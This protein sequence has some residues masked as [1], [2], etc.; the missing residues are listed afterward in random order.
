MVLVDTSVWIDHFYKRNEHLVTLLNSGKVYTHE[1]VI[2]E[3]AC[4]NIANR[5]EILNLL[6]ALSFT[7]SVTH[8]E[9][10]DFISIRHLFGR[11]L[12]YIDI[13][14]LASSLISDV[15]LWTKNKKLN[16]VANELGVAYTFYHHMKQTRL[17]RA[18]YVHR[19][20]GRF[21]PE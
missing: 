14:I 1:Y 3:I 11:G 2:G 10:L 20:S 6:K 12:G 7:S 9:I 21:A 5:D 18:G 19:C 17:R 4:G 15:K 16:L 8:D 13:H